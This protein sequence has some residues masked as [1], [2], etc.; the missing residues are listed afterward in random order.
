MCAS[1]T[2]FAPGL[3]RL[4]APT[5]PTEPTAPAAIAMPVGVPHC[6]DRAAAL[7][8]LQDLARVQRAARENEAAGRRAV[9][10]SQ[11]VARKCDASISEVLASL[12]SSADVANGTLAAALADNGP[13]L[14]LA[15]L[16]SDRGAAPLLQ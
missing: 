14:A 12:F 15:S 8:K 13:L 11:E 7:A 3:Q 5:E 9:A 16:A 4:A 6:P 10:A 2:F 1:E